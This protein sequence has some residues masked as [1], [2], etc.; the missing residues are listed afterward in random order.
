MD[1][2]NHCSD[3]IE[4]YVLDDHLEEMWIVS[5]V[6]NHGSIGIQVDM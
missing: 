1:C 3:E 2:P 4:R 6:V 5:V